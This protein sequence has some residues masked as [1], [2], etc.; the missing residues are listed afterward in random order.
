MLKDNNFDCPHCAIKRVTYTT[1]LDH[2]EKYVQRIDDNSYFKV[3]H[4]VV[5]CN[6]GQCN[7]ITYFKTKQ[8][9]RHYPGPMPTPPHS[10]SREIIFQYP[11]EGTELPEYI[12][13]KIRDYYKE[14]VE[15]FN[16]GFKNSASIMCR[17]TIYELCDR[18]KVNGKDYR[19]KIKNLGLDKRITD[20]LLNIKNIGDETVHSE[21]WDEKTIEKAIGALGIII[22]MIYVQEE[23]IKD[24]SKHYTKTNQKKQKAKKETKK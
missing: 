3:R 5:R 14:A 10:G 4:T 9:I 7:K 21:G 18:K 1:I 16:Y 22:E 17:K 2:G 6:D 24:F 12:P 23:R 20:P 15:T 8:F 19:E 13:G 11:I